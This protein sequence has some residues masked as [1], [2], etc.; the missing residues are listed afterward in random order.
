MDTAADME[1]DP[2]SD[3]IERLNIAV[4]SNVRQFKQWLVWRFESSREQGKKP[5]K[6]PYYVSG[7][8]RFGVQGSPEDRNALVTFD[9]AVAAL[10]SNLWTGIGF[11]FVPGSKVN[12]VDLDNCVRAGE[13]IPEVK[14]LIR[15]ASTYAEVSPSGNGVRLLMF[16]DLASRKAIHPDGYNV[17]LFGESGYV[18]VT[19][20]RLNGDDVE[21]CPPDVKAKLLRWAS[22]AENEAARPRLEQLDTVKQ[23]D[24]V[25]QRLRAQNMVKREF[26]DGRV[27]IVCPFASEHT[28]GSGDSDTVYFPPNTLG[29]AHGHFKCLHSHCAERTDGEF[30]RALGM[31]TVDFTAL[32]REQ[33]GP[34]VNAAEFVDAWRQTEYVVKS[35]VQRGHMVSLTGHSNAGKTAIAIRMAVCV[36]LGLPFGKHKTKQGRVVY[37]AGENADDIRCRLIAISQDMG[38]PMADLASWLFIV[39]LAFPLSEYGAQIREHVD[40]LGDLSLVIVDTRAAYAGAQDENDNMQA[41]QDARAVR[42]LMAGP[43]KPAALVLNHPPHRAE[44]ENL[45]PRGGSSYWGELDGNMT[46]WNDGSGNIT[47]HWN[48]IRGH[49]WEPVQLTLREFTLIGIAQ[50]DGD[51]VHSI[52]ADV[53]SDEQAEKIEETTRSDEDLL[54]IVMR[55]N[56]DGTIRT[57][58]DALGWKG[59]KNRIGRLLVQMKA[60]NLVKTYRR[61]WVLTAK[62]KEEAADGRVSGVVRGPK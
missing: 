58:A 28:S 62:G 50:A 21:E 37:F 22:N 30:S 13:I 26:M 35:L 41:L 45:K 40:K 5:L 32:L 38:T 12:A 23:R 25:Y 44:P 55:D 2:F 52:I 10:R 47:L 27:S 9:Q 31:Q 14:E 4:P 29:Y 53:A 49:P 56:P 43:G 11:A 59:G 46:A 3:L 60:D 16:G 18:T 42:D 7:Q 36:A 54:L 61:R 6:V 51:P 1:I 8:K 17:E 48:K 15:E 20:N 39:P 34:I 57:W 24:P 19:G 33:S